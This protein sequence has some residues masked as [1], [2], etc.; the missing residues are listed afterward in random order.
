MSHVSKNCCDPPA[1][2]RKMI[3]VILLMSP[4]LLVAFGLYWFYIVPANVNE[5]RGDGYLLQFDISIN[6]VNRFLITDGIIPHSA[7]YPVTNVFLHNF[8]SGTEQ[9]TENILGY[10]VSNPKKYVYEGNYAYVFY[11]SASGVG[12]YTYNRTTISTTLNY[13]NDI[14]FYSYIADHP[15]SGYYLFQVNTTWNDIFNMTRFLTLTYVLDNATNYV[16]SVNESVYAFAPPPLNIYNGYLIKNIRNYI[17]NF[18]DSVTDMP[19]N[20]TSLKFLIKD[21]NLNR[22]FLDYI[23]IQQLPYESSDNW[24]VVNVAKTD[25]QISISYSLYADSLMI[26]NMSEVQIRFLVYR[27]ITS[28][29]AFYPRSFDEVA[30][31][32]GFTFVPVTYQIYNRIATGVWTGFLHRFPN[33]NQLGKNLT[34]AF[35]SD[36]TAYA[37]K[38]DGAFTSSFKNVT[39]ITQNFTANLIPSILLP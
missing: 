13:T 27:T 2:H 8:E 11:G 36:I 32:S 22:A 12:G 25:Y 31:L 4:L 6:P 34:Y 38:I 14:M 21:G 5:L 26:A 35:D 10:V 19:Y 39:L 24:Y 16:P 28:E 37:T 7:S 29:T 3:I 23:V 17:Q 30:T 9:W 1:P 20:I 15:T 33:G 18:N